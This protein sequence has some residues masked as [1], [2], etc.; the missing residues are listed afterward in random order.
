MDF[1]MKVGFG[2]YLLSLILCGVFGLFYLFSPE[3]MPYHAV[4]IGATWKDFASGHEKIAK[5]IAEQ[6]APILK[7]GAARVAQLKAQGYTD[8]DIYGWAKMNGM[9]SDAGTPI[10]PTT[11]L[12]RPTGAEDSVITGVYTPQ[13]TTALANLKGAE[14]G[15]GP[16]GWV[17]E[18]GRWTQ[19]DASSGMYQGENTVSPVTWDPTTNQ[20]VDIYAQQYQ[21]EAPS[22]ANPNLLLGNPNRKPDLTISYGGDAGPYSQGG[23]SPSLT[24][25]AT[26][27]QYYMPNGGSLEQVLANNPAALYDW[28]ATHPGE[29]ILG[30]LKAPISK[31]PWSQTVA[32]PAYNAAGYKQWED[33]NAA[34]D[35]LW[36]NY[37]P[38][39]QGGYVPDTPNPYAQYNVPKEITTPLW[40]MTPEEQKAFMAKQPQVD[41]LGYEY[42]NPNC[43]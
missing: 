22:T 5:K 3:F 28:V 32:N 14:K 29:P 15:G 31:I 25:T 30:D 35:A 7:N 16:V 1:R 4:A 8:Y 41:Y 38:Y 9:F 6:K 10:D 18:G 27:E 40:K 20:W 21:D 42:I 36:G 43:R 37:G 2:C 33:W 23:Y 39:S 12:Y 19:Y 17:N 13:E 34:Q 26:W 11:G 24:K